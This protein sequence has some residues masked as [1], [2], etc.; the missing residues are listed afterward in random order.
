MTASGQHTGTGQ[1]AGCQWRQR[2]RTTEPHARWLQALRRRTTAVMSL[3]MPTLATRLLA[4]GI[5]AWGVNNCTT[6]LYAMIGYQI[7]Y[8]II[9]QKANTQRVTPHAPLGARTCGTQLGKSRHRLEK[10]EKL[11]SY[12]GSVQRLSASLRTGNLA[13]NRLR[14]SMSM[15]A[16]AVPSTLSEQEARVTP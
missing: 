7:R 16:T 9:V 2:D 15:S 13:R 5:I 10:L 1:G 8:P 11:K 4:P 12:L 14:L 6:T 3:R